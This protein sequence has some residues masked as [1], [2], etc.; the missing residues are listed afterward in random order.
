MGFSYVFL[1][2]LL[3]RLSTSIIQ[4]APT[5]ITSNYLQADSKK[6]INGDVTGTT[7]GNASTP[8]ATIPF[9]TAFGAVPNLGYGIS[10]YQGNDNLG[11]EMF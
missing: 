10:N 6:V 3:F 9:T 8:T 1:C 11:S 4:V 2:A 7:V 5:W